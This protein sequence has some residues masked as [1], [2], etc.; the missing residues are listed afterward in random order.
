MAI[1][2]VAADESGEATRIVRYGTFIILFFFGGIIGWSVW[3]PI[4][5]AVVAQGTVKVETQRKTVQHLEGGIIKEILVHEGEFV[6][7]GQPLLVLENAEVLSNLNVLKDQR[8]AE[9]AREAR[10]LA[11][12][13]LG[14]TVEFP[15]E[16][17][18]SDD[19]K[20]HALL[21]NEQALFLAKKKRIDE[22]ITI[23]REEIRHAK[24]GEA[25]TLSE[26]EA[27][28][29]N[30][31]YKEER[32][33]AGAQLNEK[34]FIEKE[35]FLQLKEGLAEKR[36]SLGQ[37]KAA[38]A[39]ARQQQAELELRIINLRNEYIKNADDELK[40]AKKAIFELEEKIRPAEL[41]LKR[42]LIT[43]PITGQ[44]ID[45]KVSTLGGVVQSGAP[46]M[47]LVPENKSLVVEAKVRT[48]DVD[49]IYVGQRA[50]IQLLAYNSRSV[51]H[52]DGTVVYIS[53]DALQDPQPTNGQLTD[54]YL[55]HLRVDEES[56][57]QLRSDHPNVFLTPGMSVTAFI[58]TK[59]K[60]FFDMLF[61]PF[62]DS[63]SRGLRIET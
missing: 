50:D 16:L 32:V 30:I 29:E 31:R 40:E 27:A 2:S 37:L 10:L 33:A 22:E 5:G 15:E 53:G 25:G 12:K 14:D 28:T 34:R 9:L 8:N 58:Q 57:G 61:K 43:A 18:R 55:T 17:T 59:P 54:Y 45:L 63:V 3:A 48:N 38:L 56:L 1:V 24:L 26:I 36:Q 19:S 39:S 41:T 47:D 21:R 60:T 52:V 13:K 7:E 51:P 46:L 11:E 62:R 42:F 23:I 44:V 35:Q 6:K 20:V 49:S 4:S